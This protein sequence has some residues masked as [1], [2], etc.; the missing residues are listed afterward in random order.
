[1]QEQERLARGADAGAVSTYLRFAALGD[2][3]TV[4]V[5]DPVPDGWRGWARLLADALADTHDVSF[6]NLATT[7]ATTASVREEQLEAALDHRPDMVSLVV[8]I[9]DTMRSGW[10][11]DRVRTDLL[12]W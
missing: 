10:S 2:S 8:G 4:G 6:Q 9:N 11:P 1:M 3:A 7:G 5:G 12:D